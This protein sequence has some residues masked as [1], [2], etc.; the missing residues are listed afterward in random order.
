M[1][2]KTLSGFESAIPVPVEGERM[3]GI[4]GLHLKASAR[5]PE[6][7]RLV[8]PMLDCMGSRG[9][10]SAGLAIFSNPVAPQRYRYSIRLGDVSDGHAARA[11]QAQE[12][13]AALAAALGQAVDC[14]RIRPD[15]AVLVAPNDA[16]RVK[17]ELAKISPESTVMGFGRS[18]ELLKDVGS[19]HDLCHRFD[20]ADRS[21]F[22][23]VGHTR[24]ATESAV[25]T[26]A[27]H[28][29]APMYDLG[30]VHN[31]SFSNPATVRR[32]L[33][34]DGIEFVT[35]NDTEVAARLIGSELSHGA[36]IHQA[37]KEVANRMDG[38][39]TLLVATDTEFAVVRDP[40]A[41]KPLVVAETE[42]YVAV[43]SEYIGMTSL[44]GIDDADVFEPEP[45]EVHAWKR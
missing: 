29:F 14:E 31:G 11:Q 9:Q 21:G 45:E 8:A 16:A 38:F 33:Q 18:L 13:T 25:T 32:A 36:D 26:D 2:H 43:A 39:Y 12:V 42:D 34:D 4:V 1:H 10:D 3:C 40:I 20:I 17:R 23:A 37:L 6:L 28:P 22:Q 30:I 27:S 35:D 15:G 41:C 19:P 5:E 7:G 24:M 44:P